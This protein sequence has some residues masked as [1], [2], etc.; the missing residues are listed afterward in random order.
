MNHMIFYEALTCKTT[1]FKEG[2]PFFSH[3]CIVS[4][5]KMVK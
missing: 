3:D 2:V 4:L 5:N 1:E